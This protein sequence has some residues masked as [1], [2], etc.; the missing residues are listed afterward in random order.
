MPTYDYRCNACGHTFEEFQS[1]S[2]QTLKKC[3]QCKKNKL[4][5]LFGTG[6]GVIFKGSGFYETDYRSDSYK[7]AAKADQ[8]PAPAAGDK[9]TSTDTA[10]KSDTAGA[11]TGS[12]GENK[13]APAKKSPKSSS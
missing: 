5:R 12:G 13:P 7:Q 3:P 6:A 9:S 11:K 10:G 8:A 2:E 1:F 4:Q